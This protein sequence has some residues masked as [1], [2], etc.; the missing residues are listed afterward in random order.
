MLFRSCFG[1]FQ[2]NTEAKLEEFIRRCKEA[3]IDDIIA[4]YKRQVKEYT[5]NLN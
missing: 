2:D 4:D 3:G 5:E 1:V